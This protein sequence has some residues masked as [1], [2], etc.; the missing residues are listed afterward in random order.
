[1]QALANFR[2]FLWRLLGTLEQIR[3]ALLYTK[4]WT[5]H[6]LEKI[7]QNSVPF[8]S[9]EKNFIEYLCCQY[10][11]NIS[12]DHFWFCRDRKIN[13]KY[14]G[15][16]LIC[17]THWTSNNSVQLS[18]LSLRWMGHWCD[19][20]GTI[21][22]RFAIKIALNKFTPIIM[23]TAEFGKSVGH[24]LHK[25]YV[26]AYSSSMFEILHQIMQ[27]RAGQVDYQ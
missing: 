12:K 24:V 3:M 5:Y 16:Y 15:S 21:K 26:T 19:M 6:V 20:N 1:M 18:T 27:D 2:I 23:F 22:I 4:N 14:F 7:I 10:S 17:A 11:K 9:T 25:F 13:I 8:V